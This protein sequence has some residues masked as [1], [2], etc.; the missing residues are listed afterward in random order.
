MAMSRKLRRVHMEKRI[1]EMELEEYSPDVDLPD[2]ARMPM[3]ELEA[4]YDE[5]F[6]PGAAKR[7]D[8]MCGFQFDPLTKPVAA[9]HGNT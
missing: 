6:G 4:Y 1:L 8:I 9:V 2:L 7:L 5:W 3:P